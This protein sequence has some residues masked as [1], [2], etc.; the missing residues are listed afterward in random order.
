[1]LSACISAKVTMSELDELVSKLDEYRAQV[2]VQLTFVF[3][4]VF[5]S[6]VV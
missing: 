1:V 4:T 6:C 3:C 5:I 2:C